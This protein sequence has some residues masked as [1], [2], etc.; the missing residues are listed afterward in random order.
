[1]RVTFVLPGYP[2]H[3]VGGYKVAY[4][5]ANALVEAGHHVSIL[6]SRYFEGS[7]AGGPRRGV[8]YL[9]GAVQLAMNRANRPN[10]FPLD[11]RVA[12][13]TVLRLR[14][15]DVP[16]AD[17][18]IATSCVT[19]P[20]VAGLPASAGSS[21]YFLQ[22]FEDWDAPR[23]FVESTWRLPMHR[24]V[25]AKWLG[26]KATELGVD[27]EYVANA[28]DPVG[29][30]PGPPIED[31]PLAISAMVSDIPWKRA[32][33]VVSVLGS[34]KKRLPGLQATTFG[35]TDAPSG[36]PDYVT[37]VRKPDRSTLQRIYQQSRVYLCASDGE[38]WH[39][40]PAEAMLSGAALVSTRIDGVT[41]YADGVASFAEPG[42]AGD[43][44]EKAFALLT[45]LAVNSSLALAGQSA[46]RTYTPR[47]ASDSFIAAL[48]RASAD[49][50]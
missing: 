20:F 15:S 1:M 17:V 50:R 39:L 11:P 33:L 2:K 34:L 48:A 6:Q 14:E 12:V 19:A 29:F 23:E 27:F 7:P 47:D 16:T 45:D 21:V 26:A 30:P 8:K 9:A 49:P 38:G 43:L 37:H 32:D 42:D 13:R 24:I 35:T 18:V 46:L 36:L 31:R 5:Y 22:H 28:V 44:E 40:P 10:W 25:I 41:E 4:E 3:P